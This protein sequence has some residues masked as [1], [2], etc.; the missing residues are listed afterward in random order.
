MITVGRNR[1]I[2]P[3]AGTEFA[4]VQESSGPRRR[5]GWSLTSYPHSTSQGTPSTSTK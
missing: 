1:L 3:T 2:A 5:N 4:R